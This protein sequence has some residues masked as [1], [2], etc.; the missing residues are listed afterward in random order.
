MPQHPL[1]LFL[2]MEHMHR[3]WVQSDTLEKF[4][5][6][7]LFHQF[8]YELLQQLQDCNARQLQRLFKAKLNMGPNSRGHRLYGQLLF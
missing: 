1:S 5:V 7:A 3:Q 4:H 2:K 6:K 8:V